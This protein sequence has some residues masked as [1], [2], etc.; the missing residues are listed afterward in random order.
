M[1]GNEDKIMTLIQME[2]FLKVIQ[3]GSFTRAGEELGLSQSAVSHAITSLES[4]LGFMLIKRNRSGVS[5]TANG[6]RMLGYISKIMHI[7]EQMEQDAAS[8]TGGHTGTIRVG[9]F[10]S[11]SI[12]WLPQILKQFQQNYPSIQVELL[13]GG[14]EEVEHWINVGLVDLGFISVTPKNVHEV[15]I[16]KKDRFVLLLPQGHALCRDGSITME[17]IAA[18]PFIMPKKG[19]DAYIRK[20]FKERKLKPSIRFE[21][22]DDHAIV[23]LVQAGLGVSVLPEMTLPNSMD[24]VLSVYIGDEI[25][26]TIGI[27][28]TS[29]TTL[30]PA[31]KKFLEVTEA[32][33]IEERSFIR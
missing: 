2:I 11:V 15:L 18:E 10:S 9:T 22:G 20:L 27:A 19:C 25:Y 17:K 5:I 14:Y 6:E 32:W 23:A 26:R 28:A 31:A 12:K 30:S 13:E 7:K 33:I 1:H 4:E 8:I 24:K 29:F 3:T 21:I 16:L